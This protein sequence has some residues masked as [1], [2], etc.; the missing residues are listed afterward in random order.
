MTLP[1]PFFQKLATA[2][3]AKLA[4]LPKEDRRSSARSLDQKKV[5][6]FCNTNAG[7]S[8][9]KAPLGMDVNVDEEIKKSGEVRDCNESS[10]LSLSPSGKRR[11][12]R[13]VSRLR[14]KWER[15]GL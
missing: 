11:R 1:K 4:R 10:R 12:M 9:T 14:K 2:L 15:A 7:P 6:T 13:M 8:S 5:A 3:L